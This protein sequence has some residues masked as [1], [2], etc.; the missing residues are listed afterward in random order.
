M[1]SESEQCN[2]DSTAGPDNVSEESVVGR[3]AMMQ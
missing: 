2:L 1:Q 3:A